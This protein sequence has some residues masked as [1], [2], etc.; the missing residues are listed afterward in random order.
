[1]TAN[2]QEPDDDAA[3]FR[4]SVGEVQPLPNQNRIAPRPAP[5]HAFIPDAPTRVEV[6]DTL[7]DFFNG[8]PPDEFI[9]NG[10]SRMT[11]RKLRRNYWPISDKLD[12]HG[13]QSDAARRALQEFL[14][15]AIEQR[16]RCVL[17][18]HGKGLN[19]LSGEAVLKIRTRHW[20]M[21][22]PGILAYCDAAPKDGGSGA[23]LIL[24]RISP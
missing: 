1:M 17:V 2:G 7:S 8:D 19:S 6:A 20:L 23:V 22:H 12:L 4:A 14:H 11:L 16:V 3:L 10:L 9:G 5:R 13:L 15:H 21:Q 18:I 24:L